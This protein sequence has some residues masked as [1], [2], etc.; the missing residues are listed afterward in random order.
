MAQHLLN[1][2]PSERG[3]HRIEGAS[4]CLRLHAWRESGAMPKV[5]TEPLI[6]GSLLH[7]GLAHY[8]VRMNRDDPDYYYSPEDAVRKLSAVGAREA[9]TAHAAALWR[10]S[11]PNIILSLQA[12]EARWRNCGWE[13][14]MV[15][16]E[17]RAHIPKYNGDGKFLFTQR[18]DLAVRDSDGIHWIVDHKSC[19]R[20]ESKTLRQ[21]ILSGQFLGY[22]LFGRKLWGDNFGGVI[23][24][25]VKLSQPYG[26]DRTVLE[27]APSAIKLFAKNL[28]LQERMVDMFEGKPP[29]EW[30]AVYSDQTCWGK[31]GKCDAFELC[32]WGEPDAVCEES[33]QEEARQE[34]GKKDQGSPREE[35]Q[36]SP[37]GNQGGSSLKGGRD[38]C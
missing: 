29:L 7:I 23:V 12:Y 24:N 22:Q 18:A 16:E 30:P 10:V 28:A 36:G 15:E 20:I 32:Q 5:E 1:A 33:R 34:V 8:Y 27:P 25:R 38:S 2:G 21:H 13:P 6:K 19:Y 37:Q 9:S 17:L 11:A 14:V 26:F 4:R 31:Y 3:W 35:K